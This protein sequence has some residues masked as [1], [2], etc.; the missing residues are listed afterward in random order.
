MFDIEKVDFAFLTEDLETIQF[1]VFQNY[2]IV[3]DE[4]LMDMGTILKFQK[5]I[6]DMIEL[7]KKKEQLRNAKSK[8]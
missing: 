1:T 3:K 7:K 8:K 4:I 6:E 2:P 5:S